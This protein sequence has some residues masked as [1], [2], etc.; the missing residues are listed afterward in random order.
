MPVTE[1]CH[2]DFVIPMTAQKT[3]DRDTKFIS[4]TS[5]HIRW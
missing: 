4:H 2:S 5:V 1:R 3:L